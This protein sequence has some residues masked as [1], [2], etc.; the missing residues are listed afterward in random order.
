MQIKKFHKILSSYRLKENP[1]VI[2]RILPFIFFITTAVHAQR[3]IPADAGS[4]VHF[5]IKN[6]GIKTGG[7]LT[8]L[9]G[10]IIFF[11]TD[12]PSC[13]F[14]VSVDVS[15]VDTDNGSRDD[16]LK[17]SEYFDAEKFPQLT[18]T[19]TKIDK[20][21]KT[22][23]GFYFFSGNLTIKGVTKPIS[24]PYHIEQVNDTYLFTGEFEINRLDFGVGGNSAVLS[25]TVNVSLSVLAKKG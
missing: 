25:N 5:T 2:K 14:N 18:I 21:N 20:T 15:T 24:F 11:T 22:E 13:S 7:D 16:H 9:K 23:S 4:K 1:M 12:L 3:Y 8:G 19:S 17:D 10:E 6:F